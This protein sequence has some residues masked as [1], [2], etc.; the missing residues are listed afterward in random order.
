[1]VTGNTNVPGGDSNDASQGSSAVPSK[2]SP[3]IAF[4]TKEDFEYWEKAF[5]EKTRISIEGSNRKGLLDHLLLV[6]ITFFCVLVVVFGYH[7]FFSVK[8]Y[9]MNLVPLVE[10]KV[11]E[12]TSRNPA[13]PDFEGAQKEI[14]EYMNDI[15]SVA[16]EVA[17]GKNAVV[18]VNQAVIAGT[19]DLTPE[20]VK[21]LEKKP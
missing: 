17:T 10:S 18:L 11:S 9:T 15:Q 3:F 1:M 6:L 5:L 8:I 7:R 14:S 20:V 19:V 4:S 2:E 12:I 13:N 16:N 21:K